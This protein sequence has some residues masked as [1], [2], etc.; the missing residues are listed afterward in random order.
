MK[1][2][3]Y[4]SEVV[5]KIHWY[6]FMYNEPN[7]YHLEY[8]EEVYWSEQYINSIRELMLNNFDDYYKFYLKNQL[9]QI[10]DYLINKKKYMKKMKK[11][12]GSRN[13][14]WLF[15]QQ[16]HRKKFKNYIVRH[17]PNMVDY[18]DEEY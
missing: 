15:D 11:N 16:S 14:L 7:M 17:Q 3:T 12:N 13:H 5:P 8:N 1:L 2:M 6:E 9:F 4:I 10:D 18:S